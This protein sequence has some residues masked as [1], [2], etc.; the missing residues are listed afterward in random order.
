MSEQKNNPAT[1]S[2]SNEIIKNQIKLLESVN[3]KLF[4][5][6]DSLPMNLGVSAEIA[7]NAQT[8]KDLITSLGPSS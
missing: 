7:R 6:L 2:N 8:I 1:G 3:E 4:K 5:T